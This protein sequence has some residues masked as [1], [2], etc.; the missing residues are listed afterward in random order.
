MGNDVCW[1]LSNKNI[2]MVIIIAIILEIIKSKNHIP[3]FSRVA[4]YSA[5]K[6]SLL[7]FFFFWKINSKNVV[8]MY[9]NNFWSFVHRKLVDFCFFFCFLFNFFNLQWIKIIHVQL[10]FDCCYRCSANNKPICKPYKWIN[11]ALSFS[12]LIFLFSFCFLFGILL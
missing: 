5:K 3:L 7:F 1:W 11:I 8:F 4:F 2:H 10:L 9:W 12:S 6:T